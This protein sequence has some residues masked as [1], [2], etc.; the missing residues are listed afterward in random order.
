MRTLFIRASELE[1][2]TTLAQGQT[3]DLKFEVDYGTTKHRYWLARTTPED[4]ERY[5]RRVTIEHWVD[6]AWRELVS[7]EGA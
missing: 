7:Y 1:T 2:R 6:G 4:G 3:D 5:R